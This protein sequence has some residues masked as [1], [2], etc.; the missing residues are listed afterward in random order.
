MSSLPNDILFTA[1]MDDSVIS[2]S[3][4]DSVSSASSSSISD[5]FLTINEVDKCINILFLLNYLF[6]IIFR[7]I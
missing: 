3:S 7:M 4:S 6:V 5:N 1:E 2:L